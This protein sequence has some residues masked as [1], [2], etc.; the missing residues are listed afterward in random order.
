MI[1]HVSAALTSLLFPRYSRRYASARPWLL[2]PYQEAAIDAV[3]SLWKEKKVQRQVVSLPVGSG[4]T[5]VFAHLIQRLQEAAPS[6]KVLVLGHREELLLQAR[7]TIERYNPRAR[8]ALERGKEHAEVGLADVVI[9]SVP[10]LGRLHSARLQKFDPAA[11]GCII[12]DEAHHATASTY[13]RILEHFHLDQPTSQAERP[14]LVGFSA[15][16]LRHDGVRLGQVFDYLAFHLPLADMMQQQWL[17]PL[18]V[19][20][21]KTKTSLSEVETL[22]PTGDFKVDQLGKAVNQPLRN[23]L[24]VQT[25]QN[26]CMIDALPRTYLISCVTFSE[27]QIDARFCG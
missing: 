24:V 5:V 20:T 25:W 15:T 18:R 23:E 7:A 6:K 1:R 9:A 3:Y 13:M 10:T 22:G 2:R 21:V 14:L 8:T 19:T 4:K 11:F 26:Y 12:I 16:V 27:C 17:C